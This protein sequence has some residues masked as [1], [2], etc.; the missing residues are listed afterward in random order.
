[1]KSGPILILTLLA[2][3]AS[4]LLVGCDNQS[5]PTSKEA[6]SHSAKKKDPNK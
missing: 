3:L 5:Q 1:M 4:L 2:V 6:A